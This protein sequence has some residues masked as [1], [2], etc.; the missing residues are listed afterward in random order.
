MKLIHFNEEYLMQIDPSSDPLLTQEQVLSEYHDIFSGRG[1][2]PGTYHCDMDLNTKAV[3]G[4]PRR[5]P[6]PVKNELKRKIDKLET[7]GV[8]AKVTKPT[9]WISNMVFVRKPNK[10]R[11]CLDPRSS[12]K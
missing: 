5:V 1:K 4:N 6:I 9:P 3:Q 7:M 8:I 2:L 10:L 12:P 11:L